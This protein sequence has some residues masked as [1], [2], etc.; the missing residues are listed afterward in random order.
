MNNRSRFSSICLLYFLAIYLVYL[1]SFAAFDIKPVSFFWGFS[2]IVMPAIE[3]AFFAML[4]LLLW[5][6]RG[7][8]FRL[9]ALALLPVPLIVLSLC[10]FVQIASVRLASEYITVLAL[11]NA[12]ETQYIASGG[13]FLAIAALVAFW[14]SLVYFALRDP[15]LGKPAP[16]VGKAWWGVGILTALFVGMYDASSS[17]TDYPNLL[18][19]DLAPA[20]GLAK[21]TQAYLYDE[22]PELDLLRFARA[23]EAGQIEPPLSFAP[24]DPFPFQRDG[25]DL[26]PLPFEPVPES[27]GRP[28]V[29]VIFAEGFSARLMQ[30][31]GGKYADLTS[32][33]D[34]F[35]KTAMVVDGYY[36]HTAATFRGLQ[37]QLTS[38]FPRAGGADIW[39]GWDETVA[40]DTDPRASLRSRS[41]PHILGMQGYET[42]FFSPHSDENQLNTMLRALDFD[43]VY[44]FETLPALLGRPVTKHSDFEP[45]AMTDDDVFG[46]LRA[47]LESHEESASEQPFFAAT[48]NIGTHAFRDVTEGELVYD[49]GT[50]PALNR[51]YEF[52]SAVGE[53]LEYFEASPFAENT[54]LIFT[55]DHATY[56]EPAVVRAL[57]EPSYRRFF[58][59]RIPLLIRAPHVELP[60]IYELDVRSSLD[61]APT[62]L[63][64]L[65]IHDAPNA[66]LGHSIF[67][68]GQSNGFTMAAIG[69]SYY[70]ILP[71]GVQRVLGAGLEDEEELSVEPPD[72]D[73][74]DAFIK[75]IQ[76]YYDVENGNKLLQPSN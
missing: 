20:T 68:D 53:F 75:A 49:D 33:L 71:G 69:E 32:N 6:L 64:L 31:Y 24:N 28:N 15:A 66:F 13:M 57:Q 51:F 7:S 40:E 56:P 73:K 44:S 29:I 4:T 9:L 25:L 39:D 18:R 52:D 3:I 34:A 35:A 12:A 42:V 19:P 23:V 54:V 30:T 70:T 38:G 21:T 65:G 72:P 22:I 16:P 43:T 74:V 59:D 27:Q 11:D 47:F 60:A 62:V 48:Y 8:R 37:G 63:H 5:R 61:L 55:S 36:N 46:G 50:N 58:V 14:G 76:Y 1:G 17:S 26:G 67:D 41:L 10:Y 45:D 2:S